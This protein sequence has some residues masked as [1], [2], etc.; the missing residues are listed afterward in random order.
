[1]PVVPRPPTAAA[2]ALGVALQA[3]SAPA[4]A[5]LRSRVVASGLAAPVAIVQDP[6]DPAVQLIVER[7]GRIR[8]L[9]G[10]V[11]AGT[12]LD[13]TGQTTTDGER[14]LLGLAFPPDAAASGRCYVNVT[15]LQGHTVIARFTRPSPGAP[16]VD[17]AS[18][19]DL[20]WPD[21]RRF[22]E[23]PFS[24]H[25]GGTIR[26]GPDG[27]LYIGMGD[28]GAGDDPMHLAQ[29]ATTLL[30]KMLRIDVG[31]PDGDARGYRIPPDNPFLDGVPVSAAGEIWAFG[32]RNPWRFSFDDLSRGGTGA[33]FIGDVGQT[34]R[35][36]INVEPRGAGGRNYG[37]RNREGTLPGAA[38]PVRPPAYL[39]LVDPIYDYPRSLGQ[40][41]T[42]GQVYR[43]LLLGPRF[44]GRYFFGDFI[45]G[46]LLSL[47]LDHDE[48]G[49]A[50]AADIVDHTDELGGPSVI[51]NIASIDV[52]GRG[53][54]YIV[55][56]RGR[57]LRLESAPG[58]T[59]TV[60]GPGGV[61]LSPPGVLCRGAC[62]QEYPL[63]TVVT[64]SPGPV[65]ASRFLEWAGDPDCAD[66]RVTIDG[67]VSCRAVFAPVDDRNPRRSRAPQPRQ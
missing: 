48:H 15:N 50:A 29:S 46:R 47:G 55:D 2:I 3:L 23:Q 17:P 60:E 19:F 30:G 12:F 59:I 63:G 57:I 51:G 13:L 62:S 25:N 32:L 34:A 20:V 10:G 67:A 56:F 16:F 40:S 14:G 43:G 21:G 37:W 64:L 35:E 45:S 1:M 24:N 33:L 4:E 44:V 26:F 5:Q 8:I 28:G 31:V 9:R 61:V 54:L 53:E 41:V 18:R 11:L 22:I 52:D 66:G 58:L 7:A 65:A 6:V 38:T 42:G 49:E 36:E 39:P 27:Y